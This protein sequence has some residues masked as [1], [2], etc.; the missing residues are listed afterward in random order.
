MTGHSRVCLEDCAEDPGS[1]EHQFASKNESVQEFH[2]E[3]KAATVD[4][5]PTVDGA[6]NPLGLRLDEHQSTAERARAVSE[7]PLQS[8]HLPIVAHWTKVQRA[9]L[10]LNRYSGPLFLLP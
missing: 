2:L 10:H 8:H 3:A 1:R 5:G 4:Y 6:R 7:N 9:L